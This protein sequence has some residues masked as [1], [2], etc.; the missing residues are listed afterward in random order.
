[1]VEA[2]VVIL[3]KMGKTAEGCI[4][5]PL[6]GFFERLSSDGAIKGLDELRDY[7]YDTSI[8]VD[9]SDLARIGDAVEL[10]ENGMPD[11]TLDHHKSNLG[12]GKMNFCDSDYAATAMIV[13]EIGKQLVEFDSALAETLLLG[14]ATDTGF[15]RYASADERVFAYAAALVR[16]GANIGRITQAILE[17]RT[18]NEI[19]LH[20]A[21][22]K[23]LKILADGRLAAAYVTAEMMKDTGCTDDDTAGLVGQLRAI[24]GVEVAIM[25]IESSQGTI[26]ISLRSKNIVDV[27]EIA[28]KFG[29]GGHAR[30]AGCS[31]T[32]VK[33]DELMSDVIAEAEV[34]IKNTFSE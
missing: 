21:M 29:G 11:I 17:H 8:T 27:S 22:F 2:L 25:F 20:T 4:A 6:P 19:H 5:D 24:G 3:R 32:D 15:F 16:T 14:I 23:T 30:A 9:S 28:L 12:F 18:L 33:L 10:L 7:A 34:A 26:H 31:I 1:S 13:Y